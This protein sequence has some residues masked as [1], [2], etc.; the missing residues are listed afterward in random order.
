M[1]CL[2]HRENT[3]L[4]NLMKNVKKIYDVHQLIHQ[5]NLFLKSSYKTIKIFENV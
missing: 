5:L 3:G 1:I 2:S 4:K